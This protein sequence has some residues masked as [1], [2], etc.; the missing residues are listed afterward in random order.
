MLE[1]LTSRIPINSLSVLGRICGIQ[2]CQRVPGRPQGKRGGIC[3]HTGTL[4]LAARAATRRL[5]TK[6]QADRAPFLAWVQGGPGP[7]K[8]I[9][10]PTDDLRRVK[11]R[12]EPRVMCLKGIFGLKTRRHRQR[13]RRRTSAQRGRP[14][15]GN[16]WRRFCCFGTGRRC[17]TPR[18]IRLCSS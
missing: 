14:V 3:V 7:V 13:R 8:P 17:G 10:V 4:V 9:G 18:S 2:P 1:V 15:R 5:G 6:I 11:L 16:R 12:L